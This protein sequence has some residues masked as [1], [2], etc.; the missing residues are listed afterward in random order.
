M[1][2]NPAGH[3]LCIGL[4]VADRQ[5]WEGNRQ[6]LLLSGCIIIAFF[7]FF[8]KRGI[9]CLRI[10]IDLNEGFYKSKILF[11]SGAL[12]KK[13]WIALEFSKQLIDK[14]R[15]KMQKQIETDRE[16]PTDKPKE[17]GNEKIKP[18]IAFSSCF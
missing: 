16:P 11:S 14:R 4:I 17:K 3:V 6:S 2:V 7:S 12:V 15:I 13:M 5:K 10:S 9:T 18:L 1:E 8:S